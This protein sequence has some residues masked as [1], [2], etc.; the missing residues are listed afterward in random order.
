M[1]LVVKYYSENKQLL[2]N[3]AK[4]DILYFLINNVTQKK[5]GEKY[6][7][8]FGNLQNKYSRRQI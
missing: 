5:T 8:L 7:Y 1:T 6:F 3:V 2:L 4:Y